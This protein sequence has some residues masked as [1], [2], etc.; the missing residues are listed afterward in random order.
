LLLVYPLLLIL[1]YTFF[2]VGFFLFDWKKFFLI[3]CEWTGRN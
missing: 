3:Y 2:I 1:K